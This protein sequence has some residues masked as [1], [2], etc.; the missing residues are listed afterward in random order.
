MAYDLPPSDLTESIISA[1][2][3][4]VEFELEPIRAELL[5]RL[6]EPSEEE[7]WAR[8]ERIAEDAIDTGWSAELIEQCERGLMQAHELFL[9]AAEQCLEATDDLGA[10]GR[11]SW[12]ARAIRH[13][14]AF[15]AVWDTLDEWHGV[16]RMT[17]REG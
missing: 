13:Q 5:E 3:Q 8:A 7:V 4:H 11:E 12:V 1:V 6:E 15:D 9:R 2:W 16:E 10:N 17:V 14:L